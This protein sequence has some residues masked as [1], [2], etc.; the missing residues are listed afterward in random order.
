MSP[1]VARRA[2]IRFSYCVLSEPQTSVNYL[3]ILVVSDDALRIRNTVSSV[4]PPA[5]RT[6]AMLAPWEN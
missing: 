1:P 5:R 3:P 2:A 6:K 4:T